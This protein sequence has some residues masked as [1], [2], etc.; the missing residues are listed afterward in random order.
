M[1]WEAGISRRGLLAASGGIAAAVGGPLAGWSAPATAVPTG[2]FDLTA[3]SHDL[4]VHRKL[5]H[6]SRVMQSLAF[7]STNR[8][9][10]V[11]QLQPNKTRDADAHGDLCINELDFHGNW[12]GHMHINDCGHGVSFGVDAISGSPELW[13]EADVR[14]DD[15]GHGWGTRLIR[16]PYTAGE[17]ISSHDW[18]P[19]YQPVLGA[20]H[21]T[22][23]TDSYHRRM[24]VRYLEDGAFH[25]GLYDI[26]SMLAT[27]S[28]PVPGSG[29]VSV[30]PHIRQP[31]GLGTFQG[32]TVYGDYLYLL[33]G[34][35]GE[36]NARVYSVDL[37]TGETIQ[38][39]A[40]H[41]G[42]KRLVNNREPEGLA[43]YVT[44]AGTPRLFL[45]FASGY[46][47]KR[48]ANVFYKNYPA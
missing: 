46:V 16:V 29:A 5:Y 44:A 22:C 30:H 11:A 28:D 1:G 20:D 3:P 12:R 39:A 33:T 38:S 36:D 18:G 13:I 48:V 43:V 14:T 27:S 23:A 6:V 34:D 31:A 40:T 7:D 2:Q 21:I 32:Y 10:F 17:T 9:L 24:V 8:R 25:Y 41:A 4:F 45:G 42:V 37:R 47:G 19:K 26:E 35:S 15:N